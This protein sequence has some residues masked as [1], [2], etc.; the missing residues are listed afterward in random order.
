MSCWKATSMSNSWVRSM[1]AARCALSRSSARSEDDFIS[2]LRAMKKVTGQY[3]G[4]INIDPATNLR[5]LDTLYGQLD[6]EVVA[7]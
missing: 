1:S 6:G 2:A 5:W 7:D 3:G 4:V